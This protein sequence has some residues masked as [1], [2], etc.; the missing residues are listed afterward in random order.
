M[1]L[2]WFYA[3]HKKPPLP[4][5]FSSALLLVLLTEAHACTYTRNT[6]IR[7]LSISITR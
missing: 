5:V 2:C 7:H 6:W 1:S 3:G 4:G